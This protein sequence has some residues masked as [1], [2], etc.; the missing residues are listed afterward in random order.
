[1]T[2][3]SRF[4]VDLA[5]CNLLCWIWKDCSKHIVYSYVSIRLCIE[6]RDWMS[7]DINTCRIL[8]IKR[9]QLVDRFVNIY[10]DDQ[11]CWVYIN[12]WITFVH[13]W[14]AILFDAIEDFIRMNY[15]SSIFISHSWQTMNPGSV[16]YKAQVKLDVR[17]Q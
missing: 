17:Q 6:V 14:L 8:Y 3:F 2:P 16:Y 13:L 11:V 10:V 7:I 9:F 12:L 1:M 5:I 4:P 15:F